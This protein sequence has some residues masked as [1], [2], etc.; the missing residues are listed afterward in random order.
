MHDLR[1]TCASYHLHRDPH[2]RKVQEL[3]G[4]ST[5]TLTLNTYSHLI[6]GAHREIGHLVEDLFHEMEEG[7]DGEEA[8]G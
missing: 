2:A 6:P 3:L 8:K 5:I 7:D 1:Y 4:H